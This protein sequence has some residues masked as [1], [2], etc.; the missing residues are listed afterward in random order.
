M[1][2]SVEKISNV[3]RKLTIS[4]P[5]ENV[6]SAYSKKINDFA[7]KANI[8]GFRPGKA[9][10]SYITKHYG[11]DARKEALSEVIEKAIYEAVSE[12][13]LKP[14]STPR[15][16]PKV[17]NPG[18][19]LEFDVSFEVLPDIEKVQ[20]AMDHIEKLKVD[21][22]D[23]DI[24][25]V[26]KQLSKQYTKWNPV[27]RAAQTLDRV[28]IDYYPIFEGKSDQENK[29]ENFPLEIGSKIMLPG[30]EDAL[31]N[32]K[33]GE[34]K[35]FTLNL[36]EDYADKDKAG[37]PVEFVVTVKQVVEALPPEINENFVKNLGVK[38]GSIDDLKKQIRKSL[39]QERDRLVKDKL[40]EQVFKQL[41]LENPI[42]VPLSLIE[43]E[44]KNIHDEI[45]PNHKSQKEHQHAPEELNSFKEIAKKRVAV[46]ILVAEY[47]KQH[48]VKAE[49][50]RVQKRIQ[51]I[52][53]AYEHPK[54]VEAWLATG[55]RLP[56]IESQVLEDQ[57]IEKLIADIKAT[58]KQMSYAELK[59]FRIPEASSTD[60]K[61]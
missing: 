34:E 42:D 47:A 17:M 57:I 61:E 13:Q 7:K 39:E 40:K 60:A 56:N 37:K 9:P 2:V 6:E 41:L 1:Q 22:T 4:V 49:K 25:Y 16:T 24:D 33:A 5:A 14:V 12:K 30:F 3:E 54:E 45:Y 20:F 38:S 31:I 43:R 23:A 52:A 15:V 21:I 32:A 8:K 19:P 59:G 10:I 35:T 29:T 28:I 48:K 51:E 50:E 55:D 46:G 53:S 18:Q 26:I 27:E 44:A 36:P 11:E 58:E